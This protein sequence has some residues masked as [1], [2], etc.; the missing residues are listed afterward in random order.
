MEDKL[1]IKIEN[2][3]VVPGHH[4]AYE[5]NIIEAFPELNG[6]LSTH[7]APVDLQPVPEF[8]YGEK[9]LGPFYEWSGVKI[10]NRYLVVPDETIV[11]E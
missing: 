7:F 11:P 6:N 3:E 4:P 9:L 2:G 5:S 8:G 10:I 1:W